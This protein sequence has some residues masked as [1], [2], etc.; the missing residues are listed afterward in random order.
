MT[1][2][3][4][5]TGTFYIL[6]TRCFTFIVA[7]AFI[8]TLFTKVLLVLYFIVFHVPAIEQ[9][10]WHCFQMTLISIYNYSLNSLIIFT[11]HNGHKKCYK[12]LM[13]LSVQLQTQNNLF[14]MELKHTCVGN[15]CLWLL[16]P[17][18][19]QNEWCHVIAW[20]SLW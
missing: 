4:F 1:S 12:F 9:C 19:L 11:L 2:D 6:I 20:L 10:M 8:I 17:V 16:I 3:L 14:L 5:A 18:V 13:G 7:R 15:A